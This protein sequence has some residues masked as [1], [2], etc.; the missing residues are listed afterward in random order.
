MNGSGNAMLWILLIPIL[1]YFLT[2]TAISIVLIRSKKFKPSF[3]PKTSVSVII[4]CRNEERTLSS[5]LSDLSAQ[6]YPQELYRVIIVDDNS[7]DNTR[8]VL[9]QYKGKPGLI[10]LSNSGSGKKRAIRTG[11]EA[12]DAELIITTD[13][14]CRMAKNWIASIVSFYEESCP[15]MIIGPVIIE[16]NGGFPARFQELEF[17]S[18][19]GITAG[20]AAMKKPVMCNGANLAF[21]RE[22]YL[23]YSRNLHEEIASGDD[24]FLLHSF[25]REYAGDIRFLESEDAVV[26]TRNSPSLTEFLNQR[27]RWLSKAGLYSDRFTIFLGIVT[28]VTILDLLFLLAAGFTD[29]SFFIILTIALVI[30]SVADLLLLSEIAKR[31]GKTGLLKWFLPVQF[32]YP[33]YVLAVAVRTLFSRKEW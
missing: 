18:L 21:K 29:A 31:R 6:N 17:L 3:N 15:G 33:F 10:V 16:G 12:S 7:N 24:I 14:D 13:A 28:F 19:Q 1:P 8:K 32:V 25:K 30:K 27:S 5:I 26:T 9:S 23:R 4:A 2:V 20:T 22:N 11:V